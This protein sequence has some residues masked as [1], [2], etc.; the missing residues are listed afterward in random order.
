MSNSYMGPR[1]GDLNQYK[2]LQWIKES[3][4]ETWKILMEDA[5]RKEE[6]GLAEKLAHIQKLEEAINK[7]TAKK[8]DSFDLGGAL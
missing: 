1:N 7:E 2:N 5:R 6:R 3:D 4:E 8:N